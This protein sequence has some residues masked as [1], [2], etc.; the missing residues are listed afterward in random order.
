VFLLLLYRAEIGLTVS[1]NMRYL[2]QALVVIR[3]VSLAGSVV[4]DWRQG[5]HLN[6]ANVQ[7]HLHGVWLWFF[8]SPARTLIS[9]AIELSSMLA[10]ILFLIAVSCQVGVARGADTRRTQQVKTA[11]LVAVCAR[12]F[13]LIMVVGSGVMMY[14]MQ[15]RGVVHHS[16]TSVPTIVRNAFFALPG[17]IAP[18]I[19]YVSI[20][21]SRETA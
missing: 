8:Q 14:S 19:V 2:A 3:G 5:V 16:V 21:T 10:F 13:H 18:L 15:Q 4:S 11:A 9:D 12:G 20:G 7:L 1:R 6:W 17:M